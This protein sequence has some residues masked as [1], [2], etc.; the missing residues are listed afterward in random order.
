[1]RA[2]MGGPSFLFRFVV[3]SLTAFLIIMVMSL[4]QSLVVSAAGGATATGGFLE[5]AANPE[6]FY[7][8]LEIGVGVITFIWTFFMLSKRKPEKKKK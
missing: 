7:I 1:M 8:L 6:T 3:A 5:G 4:A 2:A